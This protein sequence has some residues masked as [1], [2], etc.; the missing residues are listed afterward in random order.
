M[1]I[2]TATRCR[3]FH[4][5]LTRGSIA[6]VG[7]RR[8]CSRGR[9]PAPPPQSARPRPALS[10][11]PQLRRDPGRKSY[12]IR[13]TCRKAR[14]WWRSLFRTIQVLDVL[15]ACHAKGAASPSSFLRVRRARRAGATR[16]ADATGVSPVTPTAPGGP[17]LPR[18]RQ[19][20]GR[21]LGHLVVAPGGGFDRAGGSRLPEAEPR[22][23]GRSLARAT[24]VGVGFQLHHLHGQ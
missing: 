16:S 7:G 20:Q 21:H 18:P 6:I 19:R 12:P 17:E 4:K 24:D 10:G 1:E 9:V 22:R 2:W 11:E 5:M 15:E 13:R 23:S 3:R 8:D 14:S